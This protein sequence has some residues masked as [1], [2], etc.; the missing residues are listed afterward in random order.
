[1]RKHKIPNCY[2]IFPF[3]GSSHALLNNEMKVTGCGVCCFFD[4]NGCSEK[5]C[6]FLATVS[7]LYFIL[8]L[9]GIF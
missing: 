7:S 1:M 5:C 4:P 6:L 9:A 2:Q 3:R 8:V